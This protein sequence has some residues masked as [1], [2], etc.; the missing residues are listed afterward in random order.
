MVLVHNQTGGPPPVSS[1]QQIIQYS[2]SYPPYLEATSCIRIIHC[3][4]TRDYA[5]VFLEEHKKLQKKSE[6]NFL[7]YKTL[8][9]FNVIL[10]VEFS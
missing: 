6:R 9:F 7:S 4:K 1:P 3:I 5:K 10:F 2:S 8:T